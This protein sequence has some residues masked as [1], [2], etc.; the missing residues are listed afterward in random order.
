MSFAAVFACSHRKGGNTDLA[1]ELLAQAS[2]R[3]AAGPGYSMSATI[4]LSTALPAEPAKKPTASP[5]TSGA[6]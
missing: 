3:R 4:A 5:L 2:A 1:A 6:C